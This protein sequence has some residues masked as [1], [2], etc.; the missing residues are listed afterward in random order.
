M[1]PVGSLLSS[2]TIATSAI[3]LENGEIA[4]VLNPA[5]LYGRQ[6]PRPERAAAP[7]S[8]TVLVTD[9]S[10]I[11]RDL[12]CEVLRS[13]G[14]IVVE[15][16]DGLEALEQL[17]RHPEVSLLVTDVEMPRMNG[18]DLIRRIRAGQ[19]RRLPGGRRVDAR[20]R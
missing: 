6:Q 19:G 16:G 1:R 8:S 18:L 7:V 10:P 14:V 2:Q 20:Q 12:I 17:E 13:H 9:D 4:L 3:V 11:V 15:A 5:R